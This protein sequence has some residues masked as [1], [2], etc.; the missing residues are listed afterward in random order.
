MGNKPGNYSD[1]KL[2]YCDINFT[3]YLNSPQ[4]AAGIMCSCN[5][6]DRIKIMRYLVRH[7]MQ[8]LVSVL[9]SMGR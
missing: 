3:F 2:H 4:E 1:Y 5:K 7:F 6:T 9:G 8:T